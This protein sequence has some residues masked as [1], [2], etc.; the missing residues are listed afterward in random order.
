[1]SLSGFQ[2]AINCPLIQHFILTRQEIDIL[3][4]YLSFLK[5]RNKISVLE[6]NT[7]WSIPDPTDYDYT[8]NRKKFEEKLVGIIS[9]LPKLEQLYLES[10]SPEALMLALPTLKSLHL[11][12][13]TVNDIRII[14]KMPTHNDHQVIEVHLSGNQLDDSHLAKVQAADRLM[15]SSKKISRCISAPTNQ[16]L[17]KLYVSSAD[18]SCYQLRELINNLAYI[19]VLHLKSDLTNMKHI[20][21]LRHLTEVLWVQSETETADSDTK[22]KKLTESFDTFC[23]LN[24]T[25]LESLSLIV[26]SKVSAN[27]LSPLA[28][29]SNLIELKVT[30]KSEDWDEKRQPGIQLLSLIRLKVL[31]LAWVKLSNQQIQTLLES[32]DTLRKV[33]LE[34]CNLTADVTHH[35]VNYY[36]CLHPMTVCHALITAKKSSASKSMFRGVT[37]KVVRR[38][39]VTMKY[40]TPFDPDMFAPYEAL[41]LI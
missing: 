16:A 4:D 35:F 1:M 11:N 39:S 12:H 24:G 31:N 3:I 26:R 28:H 25:R 8:A 19:R 20:R 37:R 32:N 7:G 17:Q 5:S 9:S 23:L 22:R 34:Y 13:C 15:E 29:A 21:G 38:S 40:I 10:I 2:L 36:F 41:A 18:L 27:F 14:S 30:L 33:S 6:V